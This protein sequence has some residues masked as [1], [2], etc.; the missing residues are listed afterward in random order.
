M[1]NFQLPTEVK[2]QEGEEENEIK[3][4]IS[5]FERGYGHTIGNAYRRVLL[6]SLPGGAVESVKIEGVQHEFTTV[7]GVLEDVIEII[8]NLKELAVKVHSDESIILELNAEGEGEVT[9]DAIE[10]SPQVDIVNDDH[11]IL[12]LVED[13]EVNMEITFGP[14]TGYVQSDEK[15]TEDWPIG[16]I[17]VD[18]HY[19]PIRNVGYDV[20]KTRVGDITD[21][22]KVTL[23][24]ETDG[25]VTGEEAI[26]QA[27]EILEEHF[28]LIGEAAEEGG[29]EVETE[30]S[31]EE[32]EESDNEEI[33]K[34]PSMEWL[35]DDLVEYAEENDIPV[36]STANK[37]DILDKINK[38]EEGPKSSWLKD[39][40]I[41]Y[42]EA[43]GVEVE[44]G[45][46]KDDI[47]DKLE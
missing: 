37:K 34:E 5:P 11:K 16:T 29:M 21:Y 39:E 47:L 19:S 7:D 33:R 44:D 35:K 13:G 26:E 42:A 3:A 28:E 25:T 31:E 8:L 12:T 1:E 46:T 22:D 9:A 24:I 10:D 38:W 2:F 40:L 4:V 36:S 6:S 27:S 20:E 41:E 45:D 14:G 32:T 30:E 23:T 17:A 18:S 43:E 15:N